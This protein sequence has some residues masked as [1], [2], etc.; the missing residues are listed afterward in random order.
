MSDVGFAVQLKQVTPI[1]WD[2]AVIDANGRHAASG[3]GA[4]ESIAR[5]QAEFFR[6]SLIRFKRAKAW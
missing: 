5:E 4:N 6:R 1:A 2:W 3:K